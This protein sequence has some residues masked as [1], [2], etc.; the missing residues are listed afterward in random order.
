MG[1]T[2]NYSFPVPVATDL[3]KNG[4]D[5]INDLGVA[6]DTA[7]NTA[8]ATKKAGMVLLNTT[9]FSGVNSVS[10]PT[11]TFSSTY[12]NYRIIINVD[13]TTTGG[14]S[15][16][17]LRAA[18]V[19]ASGSNYDYALTERSSSVTTFSAIN[20]VAQTSIR[21]GYFQNLETFQTVIDLFNPMEATYTA[22]QINSTRYYG[23]G[24][25]SKQ[26]SAG[27]DLTTAYDSLTFFNTG[28][29]GT[30]SVYGLNK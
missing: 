27:I 10:L 22:M 23:T 3:V 17:R 9:S 12:K 30:Y 1:V 14:T 5:A 4:W 24:V 7:M 8:L 6:V 25:N 26:G 21:T 11:N 19:D 13:S 28:I 16:I 2:S 15:T 20:G 29:T 18:G